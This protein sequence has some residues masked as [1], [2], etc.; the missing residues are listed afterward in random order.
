MVSEHAA[1]IESLRRQL[2]EAEEKL[3]KLSKEVA[4]KEAKVGTTVHCQ[5]GSWAAAHFSFP[6]VFPTLMCTELCHFECLCTVY[7]MAPSNPV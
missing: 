6:M 3:G 7:S 1:N 4:E 5:P 2:S